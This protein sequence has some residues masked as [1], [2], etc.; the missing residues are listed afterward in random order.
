MSKPRSSLYA[1]TRGGVLLEYLIVATF[2]GAVVAIALAT[3]GPATV[4]N[5]SGQRAALYLSNP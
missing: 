3:V 4:R 1:D 2:A 5:Y